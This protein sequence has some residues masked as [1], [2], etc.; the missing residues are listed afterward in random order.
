M[1]IPGGVKSS[2]FWLGAGAAALIADAQSGT[3]AVA[4]AVVAAAYALSR[5]MV[6]RGEG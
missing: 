4:L 2:E 6:K 5:A 1:S 3:H